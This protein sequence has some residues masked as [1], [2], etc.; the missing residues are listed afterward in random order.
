MPP[1][2]RTCRRNSVFELRQSSDPVITRADI[3]RS[4][5]RPLKKTVLGHLVTTLACTHPPCQRAT[6]DRRQDHCRSAVSPSSLLHRTL[7]SQPRS[8]R[9]ESYRHPPGCLRFGMSLLPCAARS[10]LEGELGAEFEQPPAHDL[11]RVQ[12]LVILSG[13]SRVLVE[14]GACVESVIDVEIPPQ[15]APPHREGP[16]H[17]EIQLLDPII[18]ERVGRDQIDGDRLIARG[19]GLAGACG[20]VP[21]Q[22]RL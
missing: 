14:D 12:P 9:R 13:V 4:C 8:H 22:R 7:D 19:S 16:A 20:E 11:D 17:P 5:W 3:K 15:L 18:E 10:V 1:A 2:I 6:A 21:S